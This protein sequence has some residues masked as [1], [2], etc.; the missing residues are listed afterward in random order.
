M[1][2]HATVY[3]QPFQ[4]PF[5]ARTPMLLSYIEDSRKI[6]NIHKDARTVTRIAFSG[7][8]DLKLFPNL[9]D[10]IGHTTS[11]STLIEYLE[12]EPEALPDLRRVTFEGESG[13]IWFKARLSRFNRKYGRNIVT[14]IMEKPIPFLSTFDRKYPLRRYFLFHTLQVGI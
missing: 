10:V 4:W 9:Q 5:I 12:A 11:I 13:F 7:R 2:P 6:H 1:P 14:N 3:E 8:T